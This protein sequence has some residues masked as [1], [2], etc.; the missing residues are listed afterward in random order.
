[1]ATV[2]LSLPATCSNCDHAFTVSVSARK[3]STGGD[4]EVL[5]LNPTGNVLL[6]FVEL[7][8]LPTVCP[9]CGE[10]FS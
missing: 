7:G 3:V 2:N 6:D 8:E 5:R 9:D 10:P 4:L 1:M